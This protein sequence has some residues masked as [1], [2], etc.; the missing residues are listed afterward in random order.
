VKLGHLQIEKDNI[1]EYLWR[2]ILRKI[3]GPVQNKGGFWRIR[4]NY[5]LNELIGNADIVRFI[6]SRRI[7]WL[8]HVMRMDDKR[9]PKRILQWKPVGMRIRGR[10]RKRWIVGIEQDLQIMEVRRWRK[11]C[12]ERAEWKRITE[13]AK[14][15]S[16]F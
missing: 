5:E 10:Q 7:A 11:G 14:I 3:F 9:T 6:K 13:K 12:E 15:H 8:G 16:G 2:R 1:S 4:M